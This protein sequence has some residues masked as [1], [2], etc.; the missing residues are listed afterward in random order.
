MMENH[1][2]M[3]NMENEKAYLA[4]AN[5]NICEGGKKEWNS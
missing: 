1:R 2:K 3:G 4:E 5:D